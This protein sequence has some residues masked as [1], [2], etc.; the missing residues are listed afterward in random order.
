MVDTLK[1]DPIVVSPNEVQQQPTD[2]F[3]KYRIELE[4]GR[5]FDIESTEPPTEA[6]LQNYL[7]QQA[8]EETKTQAEAEKVPY[9]IGKERVRMGINGALFD[10]GAEIEAAVRT[11]SVSSDEYKALRD[12]LTAMN[13]QYAEDNPWEA[14]SIAVGSGLISGGAYLAGIKASAP[15]LYKFL[16]GS[17]AGKTWVQNLLRSTPTAGLAGGA[18]GVGQLEDIQQLG[19]AEGMQ[20]VAGYG[21]VGAVAPWVFGL[22]G[23][24][25][26]ASGNIL[27]SVFGSVF[28]KNPEI[29]ANKKIA[30][31]F[32]LSDLDPKKVQN[33]LDDMRASGIDES[34]IADVDINLAKLGYKSMATPSAGSGDVADFLATRG[35]TLPKNVLN[36][37]KQYSGVESTDFNDRYINKLLQQQSQEADRLYPEAHK[38]LLPTAEF[39]DF[40]KS[41]LF[42]DIY[43]QTGKVL[44]SRVVKG[45][46]QQTL[47]PLDEILASGEIDTRTLHNLKEGLDVLIGKEIDNVGNTSKIGKALLDTK[48]S[49][50]NTIRELNPDYAKANDAYADSFKLQKAFDDG[51][52]YQ[53]LSEDDLSDYINKLNPQEQEAFKVGM[54]SKIQNVTENFTSGDITRQVFKSSKQKNALKQLFGD[55]ANFRQ[56]ENT[57]KN[58][59]KTVLTAKKTVGGSPTV[60][61]LTTMAQDA[62][63]TSILKLLGQIKTG[64][65]GEAS[66][67]VYRLIDNKVSGISPAVAEQ[68]KKKLYTADKAEQYAILKAIDK[69]QKKNKVMD[70]ITAPI[71]SKNL[72]VGAGQSGIDVFQGLI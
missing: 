59:Q 36:K 38:K 53:S 10:F 14:G 5:V 7:T 12:E 43:E 69:M 58:Y 57:M 39:I 62:E 47:K 23:K 4:D 65:I 24:S 25:L 2:I 20:Q 54:I 55:D 9:E 45:Q 56:F 31:Y 1:T 71:S 72:A 52:S 8:T 50:D 68:I 3:K 32:T 15:R 33:L 70:F 61:N 46:P 22:T 51:K 28:Q 11:G 48:K 44:K 17:Q 67:D 49:F 42:T 35:E 34:I 66:K 29:V 60:E 26:S 6:D 30:E 63:N 16:M 18:T 13:K 19:T 27:A 64:Q 41:P 37:I 21:A 40:L